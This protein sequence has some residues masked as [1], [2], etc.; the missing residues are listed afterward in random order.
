MVS[1][2]GLQ[3]F[4]EIYK[5]EIGIELSQKELT[6]KANRLLNLYKVVYSSPQKIRIRQNNEKKIQPKKNSK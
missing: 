3:K 5:L 1:E 4:K 6:E 2:A